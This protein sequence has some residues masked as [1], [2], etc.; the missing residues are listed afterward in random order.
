MNEVATTT[1]TPVVSAA[2]GGLVFSSLGEVDSFART[3]AASGLAVPKHL[4]G[5]PGACFSVVLQAIEWRMSPFQV[6]NKSYSV[7]D[8]LAYEAQLISAVILQRAPLRSRPQ[9]EFFGS[10]PDLVCRVSVVGLDDKT[11]DYTSPAVKDIPIKNS[12]LWKGDPQQQLG[13]YSVRALARR[14]F[15]DVILGVYAEDEVPR[16]ERQ[17]KDVTPTKQPTTIAGKL[18]RI[19]A[20]QQPVEE[21]EPEPEPEPEPVAQ[22]E[23]PPATETIDP[24]TGEIL[25]DPADVLDAPKPDAKA[26]YLQAVGVILDEATDAEQLAKWW[27]V[28]RNRE[29]RALYLSV[30]EANAL[31]QRVIARV[32]ALKAGRAGA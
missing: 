21:A 3:M 12:P 4:R 30:D 28:P 32:E 5:N 8:R 14:H 29:Q 19:A 24:E 6:A 25:D 17:P 9:Y 7:N 15:P 31:K 11:Y 20:K 27:S 26:V 23:P 22:P 10:G 1:H 2:G 16:P 13:Y 18:D